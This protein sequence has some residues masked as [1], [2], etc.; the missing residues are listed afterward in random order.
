MNDNIHD[1]YVEWANTLDS[2]SQPEN[3]ERIR[4]EIGTRRTQQLFFLICRRATKLGEIVD[5]F[6][7]ELFYGKPSESDLMSLFSAQEIMKMEGILWGRT[8]PSISSRWENENVIRYTHAMLGLI[9]ESASELMLPL[10]RHIFF[11]TDIDHVN[12]DEEC[13][14]MMWY[15]ALMCK[16]Q[17]YTTMANFLLGN[18][19]KLTARYNKTWTQDAAYNRD[20]AAE[21]TALED[22]T[23]QRRMPP[24]TPLPLL[25][26]A[27]AAD[28]DHMKYLTLPFIKEPPT[29]SEF[30]QLVLG[31]FEE[32]EPGP[33]CPVCSKPLY[34]KAISDGY[35]SMYC[36]MELKE[37]EPGPRCPGC[38]KPLDDRAIVDGYCSMECEEGQY[39]SE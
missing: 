21:M 3:L 32:P 13:G 8:V 25:D 27:D 7:K 1:T 10:M 24:L 5:A 16:V 33:K 18:R 36:A 4:K 35:C 15:M 28:P 30:I 26:E 17:G 9:G 29:G 31:K 34:G 19:A 2:A 20:T 22:A 37:Q 38:G 11:G 12:I 14:D 23:G 6:K 39:E